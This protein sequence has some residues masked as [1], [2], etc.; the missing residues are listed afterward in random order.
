MILASIQAELH[1]FG[2]PNYDHP[3]R[4]LLRFEDGVQLRLRLAG[5]GAGMVLDPLPLETPFDM[6]ESGRVDR[7]DVTARLFPALAGA[8]IVRL[9]SIATPAGRCVGLALCGREGDTFCFWVDGDEFHWGPASAL[10]AW[11]WLPGEAP[12]IADEIAV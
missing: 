2:V 1:I 12:A 5:D 3:L 11:D 7:F 6:G 8:T 4:L 9:R 10:A